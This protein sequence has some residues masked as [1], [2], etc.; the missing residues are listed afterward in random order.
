MKLNDFINKLNK[1][2][3]RKSKTIDKIVNLDSYIKLKA[4]DS[5]WN[6]L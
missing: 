1:K 2:K 5:T 6:A 3:T 4:S